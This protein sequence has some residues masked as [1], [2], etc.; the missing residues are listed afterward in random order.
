MEDWGRQTAKKRFSTLA[1][2]QNI[3]RTGWQTQDAWKHR[4]GTLFLSS[5]LGWGKVKKGFLRLSSGKTGASF[6]YSQYHTEKSEKS[7]SS[8]LNSPVCLLSTVK[9]SC[10]GQVKMMWAPSILIIRGLWQL[11]HWIQILLLI[12]RVLLLQVSLTYDVQ[13]ACL[14]CPAGRQEIK[15][16]APRMKWIAF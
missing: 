10:V 16:L 4:R 13:K 3:R 14:K 12:S 1:C 2:G 5:W 15:Y 11:F 9:T 6:L 7:K 8:N